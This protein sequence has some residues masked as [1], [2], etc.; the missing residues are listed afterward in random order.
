MKN[1]ETNISLTLGEIGCQF[2]SKIE[3]HIKDY[4][5][6]KD[7]DVE[8]LL[9][10][11]DE[12]SHLSDYIL[13]AFQITTRWES[14]YQLYFHLKGANSIYR[15]FDKPIV[16]SHEKQKE[17]DTISFGDIKWREEEPR[18][19]PFVKSMIIKDD[20]NPLASKAIPTIWEDLVV[21]FTTVGI[22]QAVLLNEIPALFPKGWHADYLRKVYVFSHD[23][24]QSIYDHCKT[25][26]DDFSDSDKKKL[27]AY[28]KSIDRP[29]R[30]KDALTTSDLDRL[31]YYLD[32]MDIMP[33]VKIDGDNAVATFF[34]WN[35]WS[36]FCKM[37]IPVE[38]HGNSVKIGKQEHETL[39]EYD[40]RIVY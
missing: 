22:W 28:L 21:S 2:R 10:P 12:I 23:D 39:V 14:I 34:Y 33:S 8:W 40:C 13:D 27:D 3:N 36:G 24:M 11:L 30:I 1:T 31:K 37:I 15:P 17:R 4:R 25:L 9:E 20:L 29:N 5:L 35:D 19:N 18:P 7:D 6:Q 16:R 38:K 32:R 26:V